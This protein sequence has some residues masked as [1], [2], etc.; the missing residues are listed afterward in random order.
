MPECCP[1]PLAGRPLKVAKDV[2]DTAHVDV[3]MSPGDL[4][5]QPPP[6]LVA[7]EPVPLSRCQPI[8]SSRF[9]GMDRE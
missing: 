1:K 4:V 5:R 8:Q 2:I 3:W 6:A 9:T 7:D